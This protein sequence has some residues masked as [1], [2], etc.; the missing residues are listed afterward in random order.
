MRGDFSRKTFDRRNHYSGVLM[1]QGRV[2]VDADWNEQ[3]DV[4]T[5][6]TETEAIDTI[7]L[8]GVPKGNAGFKI[9]AAPGGRDLALAAGR[10]YVDGLLCE[11]DQPATYTAQP[12]F[13][14]PDYTAP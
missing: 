6:R 10:M 2:Q 9:G 8:S 5:Y 13:P 12:Y 14:N 7:G 4:Q 3:V 1:Q 11:L